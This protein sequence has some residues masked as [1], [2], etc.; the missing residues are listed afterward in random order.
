MA[1]SPRFLCNNGS[2]TVTLRDGGREETVSSAETVYVEATG[3]GSADCP[4]A[5]LSVDTAVHLMVFFIFMIIYF[6]DSLD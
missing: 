2:C 4:D 6:V 1:F 3:G 5:A